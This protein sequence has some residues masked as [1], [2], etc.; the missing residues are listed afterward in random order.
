VATKSAAR[1]DGQ[2]NRLVERATAL[3]QP[4]ILVVMAVVVGS[5]V[6]AIIDVVFSTLQQIGKR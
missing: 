4:C 3:I 6:Y 2:F 5:I 1:L